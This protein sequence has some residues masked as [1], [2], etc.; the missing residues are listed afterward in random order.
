MVQTHRHALQDHLH[1]HARM[2][3]RV[4]ISGTWY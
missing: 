2:G 4:L 3:K 1:R